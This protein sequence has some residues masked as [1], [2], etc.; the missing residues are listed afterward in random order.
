MRQPDLGQRAPDRKRRALHR[1]ISSSFSEALTLTPRPQANRSATYGRLMPAWCRF[2]PRVLRRF[3]RPIHGTFTVFPSRGTGSTASS[4]SRLLIF[5]GERLRRLSGS[6]VPGGAV[7]GRTACTVLR[8]MTKG[9]MFRAAADQFG[10]AKLRSFLSATH[11]C[12]LTGQR[13]FGIPT[14]T[15][16]GVCFGCVVRRAFFA[17][18]GLVDTTTY[19]D[20]GHPAGLAV[21]LDRKSVLP[22]M[23]RFR[24]ETRDAAGS[25]CDEP[26]G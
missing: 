16:C 20:Q 18:A 8:R 10:D 15:Q 4:Q 5:G 9:E 1:R 3:Y 13:A 22:D 21:V 23:R 25:P 19:A 12:G 11:S 26:A 2:L 7:C 6:P 24:P 17:A 14:T